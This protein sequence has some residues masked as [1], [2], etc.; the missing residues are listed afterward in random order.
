MC[1]EV[2]FS[3]AD[4]RR[5]VMKSD[6]S[7]CFRICW[8]LFRPAGHFEANVFFILSDLAC[9]FHDGLG[10]DPWFLSDEVSIDRPTEGG[11]LRFGSGVFVE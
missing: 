2:G 1:D 9:A 11:I 10:N 5:D 3:V 8:I 4:V 6:Q 7:L